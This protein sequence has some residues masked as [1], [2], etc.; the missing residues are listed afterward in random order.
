M[1]DLVVDPETGIATDEQGKFKVSS[2][3]NV[4]NTAPYGHNG[5]FATLK[6]IVHFY[7]TRDRLGRGI[8]R[9]SAKSLATVNGDELGHL[10]LS[11]AQEDKIVLLPQDAERQL[12]NFKTL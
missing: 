10:G 1:Y 8:I 4:G 12:I 5:Y 3:R 2:L 7:N 6:E 9:T 11:S